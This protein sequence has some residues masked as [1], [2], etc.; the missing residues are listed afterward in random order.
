MIGLMYY[1]TV[2]VISRHDNSLH[3]A[4]CK[5]FSAGSDFNAD[6]LCYS[7]EHVN[8]EVRTDTSVHQ[9]EPCTYGKTDKQ[10]NYEFDSLNLIQLHLVST[11]SR[12]HVLTCDAIEKNRRKTGY[13]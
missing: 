4:V 13:T 3:G 12:T 1:C 8:S 2:R 9:H 7:V 5:K 11:Y 6:S 10:V